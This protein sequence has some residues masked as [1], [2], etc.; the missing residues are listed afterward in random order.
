MTDATDEDGDAVSY[1]YQW[2]KDSALM[3]GYT[4]ST[5]AAARTTKGEVWM[6]EV[7]ATDGEDEGASLLA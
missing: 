5:V 6:V 4:T 1:N 2:Y 3:S 7:T